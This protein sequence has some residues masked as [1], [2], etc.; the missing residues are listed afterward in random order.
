VTEA[1][2]TRRGIVWG[3]LA[4]TFLT[5]AGVLPLLMEYKSGFF[6]RPEPALGAEAPRPSLE[7]TV[8]AR[9]SLE[10]AKR[11]LADARAELARLR[12]AEERLADLRA[13]YESELAQ[14]R[15]QVAQ[16][17]GEAAKKEAEDLAADRLKD[18][19]PLGQPGNGDG[20]GRKQASEVR[21][22]AA[23]VAGPIDTYQALI[24]QD[25]SSP[26][27]A[28]RVWAAKR[29]AL[30][31]L[32]DAMKD[33]PVA[34]ECQE[35]VQTLFDAAARHQDGGS[36]DMQTRIQACQHLVCLVKRRKLNADR[37]VSE[38]VKLIDRPN[39]GLQAIQ[40]LGNLGGEARA[41]VPALEA[42]QADPHRSVR[43]TAT[44]A[45]RKIAQDPASLSM[46]TPR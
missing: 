40:A 10:E 11:A 29:A 19:P 5:Q 35:A 26:E 38:L 23:S 7:E 4:W 3:L 22:L 37:V 15:Q 39:A 8:Q 14:A 43:D 17:R 33:S 21:R 6:A 1:G 24:S 45:L 30:Q 41:A 31:Q 12:A 18:Q 34:G 46:T 28:R 42:L 2:C 36:A 25:A 9:V 27:E 16:A 44:E 32:F 13:R 20:G